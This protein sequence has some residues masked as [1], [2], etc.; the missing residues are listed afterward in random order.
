MWLGHSGASEP[1]GVR[2]LLGAIIWNLTRVGF[3]YKN[4]PL[5]L[6][7]IDAEMKEVYG[8]KHRFL[9]IYGS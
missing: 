3:L 4:M 7:P 2:I 1:T 5:V 6:V 9:G 8:F